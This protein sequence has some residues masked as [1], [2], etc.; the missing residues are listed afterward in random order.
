MLECE[1][2]HN[3]VGAYWVDNV[4]QLLVLSVCRSRNNATFIVDKWE[5]LKSRPNL[6]QL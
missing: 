3:G 6:L 4:Q 2:A 1:Q 5:K